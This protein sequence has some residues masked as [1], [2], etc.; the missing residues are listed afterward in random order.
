M[1]SSGGLAGFRHA[2]Q[3]GGQALAHALA[4][5]EESR[6][7]REEAYGLK[8]K[9]PEQKTSVGFTMPPAIQ[10]VISPYGHFNLKA[11]TGADGK[12]VMPYASSKMWADVSQGG[13][14]AM[15]AEKVPTDFTTPAQ[16]RETNF[17][18]SIMT[19]ARQVVAVSTPSHTV[20]VAHT[21]AH[22]NRLE[23]AGMFS[24]STTGKPQKVWT[25][26]THTVVTCAA[27]TVTAEADAAEI[28]F[29]YPAAADIK[30]G[31]LQKVPAIT[32]R[33][34]VGSKFH[35]EAIFAMDCVD[36]F[37]VGSK[38][39]CTF[40]FAKAVKQ[41]LEWLRVKRMA[42][43]QF[44]EAIV[45]VSYAGF[46]LRIRIDQ[47]WTPT[48]IDLVKEELGAIFAAPSHPAL[49]Q[50][51][52]TYRKAVQSTTNNYKKTNDVL[53]RR[54]LP[55][56]PK[57]NVTM[58]VEKEDGT[59]IPHGEYNELC[60]VLKKV[61]R[62]IKFSRTIETMTCLV[63]DAVALDGVAVCGYKFYVEHMTPKSA[64]ESLAR[65]LMHEWRQ[66]LTTAGS[67]DAEHRSTAAAAAP[68]EPRM[69]QRWSDVGM[70]TRSTTVDL[71]GPPVSQ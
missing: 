38:N 30:S 15:I 19:K 35:R 23:S 25:R 3:I 64:D 49:A 37:E 11:Q 71:T 13:K 67:D 66:M 65:R 5:Q 29:Y 34:E 69:P 21:I 70:P 39:T 16:L 33:T 57:V 46:K 22:D 60:G 44:A 1:A 42:L 28:S 54:E 53:A 20:L 59:K 68:P 62:A 63:D 41:D 40:S 4:E 51:Y 8:T 32:G 6:A 26:G 36:F 9:V 17:L 55:S 27:A 2:L 14:F 61:T 18:P 50:A 58:T 10:K 7:M 52:A 12:V 24:T 48:A 45:G 56:T 43:Q 31:I 47:E